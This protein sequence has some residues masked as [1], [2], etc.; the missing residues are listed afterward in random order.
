M[1]SRLSAL[2]REIRS[3]SVLLAHSVLDFTDGLSNEFVHFQ[4]INRRYP[5]LE[6]RVRPRLLES[7]GLAFMR[8]QNAA[9][10]D[11]QGTLASAAA[12]LFARLGT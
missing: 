1:L 9:G 2:P 10:G 11:E 12:L 6:S 3:L 4:Q 5:T 7:T 8:I